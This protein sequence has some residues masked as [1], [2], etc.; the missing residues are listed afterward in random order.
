[1]TPDNPEK[2][3]AGREC[4]VLV[5]RFIKPERATEYAQW[6]ARQPRV[7][8][9]GFIDK[10]LTRPADATRLPP[11]LSGFHIAGNPGCVTMVIVERWASAEA[12]RAF[13]PKA[14]TADMDEYDVL[15]RQRVILEDA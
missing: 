3:M 1:M 7:T 12:F 8:A 13:V 14:S 4:I 10:W 2:I 6:F 5:R 9:D 11:G 15:P